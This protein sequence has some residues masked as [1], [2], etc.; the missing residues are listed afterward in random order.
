LLLPWGSVGADRLEVGGSLERA[1]GREK[2]KGEEEDYEMSAP[3]QRQ[4][5]SLGDH[6]SRPQQTESIVYKYQVY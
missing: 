1:G 4:G 3:E 2:F 5:K 6:L